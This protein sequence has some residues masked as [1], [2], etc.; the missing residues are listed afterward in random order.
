MLKK[1]YAAIFALVVAGLVAA[2]S[3]NYAGSTT[4]APLAPSGA[5]E[6]LGMLP[7]SDAVAFID[8][9]RSLSEVLPQIF[10]NQA[11]TL[12]RINQEIDKFKLHTGT[13]AH[14]IDSIAIAARFKQ[15][16]TNPDFVAGLVRGRFN[17]SEAIT[18]GLAK[19]KADAESRK[20]TFVWTE[21][22]YEG[23][24]I[25]EAERKGGFCLAAIDS[26]TIAFGDVSG[27]KA[28][29]DVR[30]GRGARVDSSLVEL[31]TLNAAAVAGFAANVPASA[32]KDLSG[33]DEFGA[34]FGNIK[35]VY[36]SA[37]ATGTNG[38]LTVMLRSETSEQAQALA[39]KL[40][41][42]KQLASFYFSRAESQSTVNSNAQLGTLSAQPVFIKEKQVSIA[43][44]RFLAR[45]AKDVTITAEGNDVKL[46]LEEPLADLA[47]IFS[48][49]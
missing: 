37:E 27:I 23:T 1:A 6:L 39:E 17:A 47:P 4:A 35:Q 5:T 21:Q 32:V 30:A 25:Y 34:A 16:T 11:T 24:T 45:W 14:A 20:R 49:R 31:A 40:G 26:N 18:N 36:G 46:R 33:T 22:Q 44:P 19:A 10:A 12:D 3:F 29:I 7:A 43:F 41:T 28:M 38:A 9:R 13:D 15:N 42:L 48:G 8:A 2:A